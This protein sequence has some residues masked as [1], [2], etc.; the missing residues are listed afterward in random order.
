MKQGILGEILSKYPTDALKNYEILKMRP[1][2]L[3]NFVIL[4]VFACANLYSQSAS[5][6]NWTYPD[7][8][9][10][11]T[12][13]NPRRSQ[14]QLV[15]S[16]KIKWSTS[17]ISGD[18]KPLVGNIV[19]DE[20]IFPAYPYASNEIVAIQSGR[21][22]VVDASGKTHKLT[23]FLPFV[24]EISALIDTNRTDLTGASTGPMLMGIETVEMKGAD[25]IAFSY[26]GG[27]NKDAD[28]V[29]Y[30]RR[31][32]LDM[33][34]YNPNN[35]ASIK[36]VFGKKFNGENYIYSIINTSL[37]RV[38]KSNTGN[39]LQYF[40]GLAQF[41]PGSLTP[42]YP[43]PDSKDNISNRTHI[44][45]EANFSQ[46]SITQLGDGRVVAAL[47]YFPTSSLG[48]YAIASPNLNNPTKADAPYLCSVNISGDGVKED[49]MPSDLSVFING[50]RPRIKP[51]YVH[52]NDASSAKD[53]VY[54]LLAEEYLGRDGSNGTSRLHLFN[55]AGDPTTSPF[56][57]TNPPFVGGS[58]HL[59][60]IAVGDVDGA[61]SN[62]WAPYYPNNKGQEIIA[63]QSSRDFVVPASKLFILRYNSGS[64]V[65]KP[66]PP[67]AEL[68][69]LDT[70]CSQRINGWVAAVNDIDG[71]ADRKDE[72]CLVDGSILRIVR[73]R[74]YNSFEFK[75]GRPLDTLYSVEFRNQ[76]ISNVAIADLEGDGL[77]DII[78]TTHDSTYVLGSE[79]INTVKA[80]EPASYREYCVGDSAE[81]KWINLIK[82]PKSID[83]YFQK[84]IDGVDAGD[85]ILV[86]SEF[87]NTV[88]T[89]SYKF[90][91]DNTLMGKTGYFII[92]A[93]NAPDKAFDK[94]A[95]VKFNSPA[96]TFDAFGD[97]PIYPG[98]LLAING[99]A[100]CADSVEIQ[101]S[102]NDTLWTKIIAEPV[103]KDGSFRISFD[104]PCPDFFECVR[105]DR[106]KYIYFRGIGVKGLVKDTSLSVQSPIVPASLPITI[107]SC[108]T[109][110][111]TR[112]FRW[113][114]EKLNFDCNTLTI[115]VSLNN[116]NTF[117][118][119]GVAKISDGKFV[120]NAP[121]NLPEEVVMRYC[122][123]NSCIRTDT[124][125]KNYAPKYINVV[126]PNP[127]NPMNETIGITY[128][129]PEDTYV[130]IKILDEANRLVARPINGV[131]RKA[132]I[133]YCD[134]WDGVRQD[135]S[136]AANGLYY[137]SLELS[138]GAK[139]VY[140]IY[141]KK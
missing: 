25:S 100:L 99:S 40:R 77:N 125:L 141:I 33:R 6:S 85:S 1:K 109:G 74:D 13:Y 29:Q 46:P 50:V 8:N 3:I 86:H 104:V 93:S 55:T 26:I 36:P 98:K 94:T 97:A 32:A 15:D 101:Y 89:C 79:I 17:A 56:L 14:A 117:N 65:E 35:F 115:S 51:Y 4:S 122:C 81:V 112:T 16:F 31:L 60:S 139:Q 18:I 28:T 20:K 11:G 54:I 78:V 107:D 47:P 27:Y 140:P 131:S 130:T 90:V 116:G 37:P 48:D 44:A 24:K 7:G 62:S 113:Q 66:T 43:L 103:A 134:Y 53:S 52:I 91:V 57:S 96:V 111:P 75:M 114:V 108:E 118:E 21:I 30:L 136:Y 72:I 126:E 119:I 110:C 23:D 80:L 58:N 45:G 129:V 132:G 42:N 59:W 83:I 22:V 64:P 41:V 105:S 106:G 2:I 67:G 120:W 5:P 87:K 138:S 49:V 123:G 128:Y 121:M 39:N 10:E 95:I 70:I 92:K 71:A 38:D 19:N 73:L 76:T 88:D 133:A 84:T 12:R 61:S 82:T 63:T 34:A 69:P 137:V 9:A 135:G 102:N 127:F 68:F 124:V